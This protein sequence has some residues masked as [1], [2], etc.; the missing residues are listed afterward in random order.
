ML[1]ARTFVSNLSILS[2]TKL[3]NDFFIDLQEY[4]DPAFNYK[5]IVSVEVDP[6]NLHQLNYK[7]KDVSAT[8]TGELPEWI[9][10]IFNL[11]NYNNGTYYLP[12]PIGTIP[13]ITITT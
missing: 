11:T 13:N 3:L 7:F 1:R 6:T 4:G 9:A 10:T 5:F 2:I 8:P 12:L